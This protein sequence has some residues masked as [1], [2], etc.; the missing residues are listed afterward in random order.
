MKLILYKLWFVRNQN[1]SDTVAHLA[2]MKN[3]T[4]APEHR[5]CNDPLGHHWLYSEWN[6]RRRC[7]SSQF[8]MDG[9]PTDGFT[10]SHLWAI[11]WSCFICQI[12]SKQKKNSYCWSRHSKA[13]Y[14]NPRLNNSIN[15]KG[16]S[17]TSGLILI[18]RQIQL[19]GF[20]WWKNE[21]HSFYISE[22][23]TVCHLWR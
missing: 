5:V 18:I 2:H 10:S 21:K 17:P 16:H 19:V 22:G 13:T 3:V 11:K 23:N 12:D 7:N 4:L 15:K 6:C 1:I 9:W 20:F 8:W 14:E